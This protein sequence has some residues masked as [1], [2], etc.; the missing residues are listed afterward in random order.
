MD[1]L[2]CLL[3]QRDDLVILFSKITE[4]LCLLLNSIGDGL[5]RVAT[6][7]LGG[8]WMFDGVYAGLSFILL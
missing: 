1:N 6:V 8:Q 5:D 7:E 2:Y 4:G 3:K